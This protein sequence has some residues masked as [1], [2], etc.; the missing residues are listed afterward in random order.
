MSVVSISTNSNETETR[1]ITEFITP[2]IVRVTT[3]SSAHPFIGAQFNT[4]TD[5]TH[6]GVRPYPFNWSIIN[7]AIAFDIK[8]LQGNDGINYASARAPFSIDSAGFTVYA[9][10]Q[11]IGSY[12]FASSASDDG[13]HG[14]V[15]FRFNTT[16][17]TYYIIL[18]ELQSD[19]DRRDRFKSLLR[20]YASLTDTSP[21]WSPLA[22]GDM[23]WHNDF[24]RESAWP[25]SVSN[26]QEFV[27][28]V[29]EK[30]AEERVRASAVM[31]D[32]PYGTGTEDWGNYNFDPGY[33]PDIRQLIA[34]IAEKRLDFQV[35]TYCRPPT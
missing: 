30:L 34:D 3:T 11:A 20:Q 12:A 13:N 24:L 7:D 32:W 14:Q 35:C 9:D 23:F 16:D 17:P 18:P 27:V 2:C 15:S 26:A 28:D 5:A 1:V 25:E 33:W 10:T 6:Y 19:G 29:V 22:Y 8:G 21:F 4:S 31:I